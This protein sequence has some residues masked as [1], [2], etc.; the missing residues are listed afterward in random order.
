M[1][2]IQIF[3]PSS[4]IE[5]KISIIISFIARQ[6]EQKE[7]Y[8]NKIILNNTS[9][10]MKFKSL[11]I[12]TLALVS[13]SGL[14][15]ASNS[16]PGRGDDSEL[17]ISPQFFPPGISFPVDE[18]RYSYPPFKLTII[19]PDSDNLGVGYMPVDTHTRVPGTRFQPGGLRASGFYRFDKN[20][21]YVG[22]LVEEG[23]Q[24]ASEVRCQ[25]VQDSRSFRNSYIM[26]NVGAT[27][28]GPAVSGVYCAA[29]Y[30]LE[31]S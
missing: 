8:P 14:C 22:V 23:P 13:S 20:Y 19:D 3:R 9:C 18:S 15:F 6:R 2:T 24:D 26:V 21:E 10:R 17:N 11:Y 16:Y 29:L 12:T 25:F 28:F 7:L 4:K 27:V 5:I 30:P 1:E 31:S